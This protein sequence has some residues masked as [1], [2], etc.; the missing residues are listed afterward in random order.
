MVLAE[1]ATEISGV[2]NLPVYFRSA[3]DDEVGRLLVGLVGPVGLCPLLWV[4][5]IYLLPTWYWCSFPHSGNIGVD[6]FSDLYGRSLGWRRCVAAE[7]GRGSPK[8]CEVRR[9]LW[10]ARVKALPT[11][12]VSVPASV[13]T[14]FDASAWFSGTPASNMPL[15][16]FE[17]MQTGRR[18]RCA[19]SR[20]PRGLPLAGG[21][22]C[23][24][25]DGAHPLQR[26]LVG[27]NVDGVRGHDFWMNFWRHSTKTA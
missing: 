24:V 16:S 5:S 4:G 17:P 14:L 15:P 2:I 13:V 8:P 20:E 9:I 19:R 25:R 1:S 27:V 26:Q 7:R 6:A 12:V 10:E 21:P 23:G 18:R 3:H 22:N 11:V